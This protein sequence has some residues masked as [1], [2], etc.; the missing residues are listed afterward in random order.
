MKKHKIN[1]SKLA[2]NILKLECI[3][4]LAF[5]FDAMFISYLLK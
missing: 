5:T 4:L 1:K 3:A 2:I